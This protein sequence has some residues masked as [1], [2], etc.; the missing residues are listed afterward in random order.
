MTQKRDL[1]PLT[2]YVPPAAKVEAETRAAAL[3]VSTG[4]LLRMIMLGIQSPLSAPD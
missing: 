4:T 3:S 1:I 2:V